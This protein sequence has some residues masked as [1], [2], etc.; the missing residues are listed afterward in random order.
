M[1]MRVITYTYREIHSH[2]FQQLP[3]GGP[4]SN[5]QEKLKRFGKAALYGLR[6]GL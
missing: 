6:A 5:S 2:M 1:V 4:F 3:P